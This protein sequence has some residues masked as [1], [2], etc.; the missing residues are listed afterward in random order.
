MK[1]TIVTICKWWSIS[2]SPVPLVGIILNEAAAEWIIN[3]VKDTPDKHTFRKTIHDCNKWTNS[4][5][6]AITLVECSQVKHNYGRYS[7]KLAY[8]LYFSLIEEE[9]NKKKSV[10]TPAFQS[11]YLPVKCGVSRAQFWALIVINVHK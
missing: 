9:L 8:K 2:Y 5:I 7:D 6:I 10:K 4:G 11:R 3:A 1:S